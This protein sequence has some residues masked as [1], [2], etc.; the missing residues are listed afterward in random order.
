[1]RAARWLAAVG[2]VALTGCGGATSPPTFPV[3]AGHGFTIALPATPREREGHEGPFVRSYVASAVDGDGR[4]FEVAAFIIDRP[5][6]AAVRADLMRRVLRGLAARPDARSFDAA[7]ATGVADDALAHEVTIELD[8][9]RR[10]HWRLLFGGPQ[11]MVQLSVVGAD[12]DGLAERAAAFFES[13]VLQ[14]APP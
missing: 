2:L 4:V 14:P 1:M 13:F 7:P 3:G 12:E 10:G 6:T 9:G 11:R 8:G 5:L